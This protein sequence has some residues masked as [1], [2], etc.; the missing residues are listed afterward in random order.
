MYAFPTQVTA[1]KGLN[2]SQCKTQHQAKSTEGVISI[3]EESGRVIGIL[4]VAQRGY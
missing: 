4:S 3:Q 2:H 1:Y